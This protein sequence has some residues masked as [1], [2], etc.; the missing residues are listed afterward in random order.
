MLK[1]A[2]SIPGIWMTHV[3]NKS[4]KMKQPGESPLFVPGQPCFHKCE[5]C[6]ADPKRG[7]DKYKKVRNDCMQCAKNKPYELLKTGMVGGPSIVFCLYHESGK[8]RIC[9]NA[10][11]CARIV[12]FNTNSLLLH[13]SGQE[14]PCSKEEYVEVD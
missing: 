13:C 5:K 1:D 8:S 14:M 11:V 7:R 3:F 9:N 2:V 6:E 12:G 4:L 10:K